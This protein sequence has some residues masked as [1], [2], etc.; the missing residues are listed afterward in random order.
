MCDHNTA[1]NTMALI[2]ENIN[3]NKLCVKDT[4]L[5]TI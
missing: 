3:K 2:K 4:F 1:Y 5:F